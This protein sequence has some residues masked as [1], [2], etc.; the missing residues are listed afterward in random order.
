MDNDRLYDRRR[1]GG[2]R[3]RHDAWTAPPRTSPSA[4]LDRY[5][6]TFSD[7]AGIRLADAPARCSSCS[8]SPNC[9]PPA[10]VRASPSPRRRVAEA[11]WTTPRRMRDAPARGDRRTG[12]GRIPP[13]R[14]AHG[15]ALR[16]MAELVLERYGGDLRRLAEAAERTSSGRRAGPGGEGIGPTG[17]AV[18][19]REVQAV[20]P[21]VRPFLDARARRAPGEPACPTTPRGS[22]GLVPPDELA[23]FAAGLVRVSLGARRPIP[24]RRSA[25]DPPVMS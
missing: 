15:H 14:R 13:L 21:W 23:R 22:R 1:I 11:G 2:S 16:E 24:G 9:S 6:P 8:S 18:F 7:E 20:W 10:S 4:V 17:A 3:G 25:A 19:L 5:G 12:P